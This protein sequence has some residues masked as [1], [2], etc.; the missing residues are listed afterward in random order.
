TSANSTATDLRPELYTGYYHEN[1][2]NAAGYGYVEF[3]STYLTT[4][5]RQLTGTDDSIIVYDSGHSGGSFDT[6]ITVS[7]GGSY[8]LVP[9]K[10]H[11]YPG[12]GL[13]YIFREWRAPYGTLPLRDYTLRSGGMFSG[14]TIFY[15][16]DI[17]SNAGP[18][19]S[20]TRT[21]QY[22]I[23]GNPLFEDRVDSTRGRALITSFPGHQISFGYNSLIIEALGRTTKI[24]FDTIARSGSA[25]PSETM[26]YANYGGITPASLA[27]A[28]YPETEPRLYKSFF[29]YVTQ[30]I[31]PENRVTSFEYEKV[32]RRY[33]DFNFPWANPG[34]GHQHLTLKNYRL[35]AVNEPTARYAL[36]Y[37]SDLSH[38]I[39]VTTEAATDGPKKMNDVA[40]SVYK[41]DND[42]NRLTTSAYGFTYLHTTDGANLP[43]MTSQ[44][45]VDNVTGQSRM[46]TFTYDALAL[47]TFNVL[48][49]QQR[50]TYLK[51]T[52]QDDGTILSTVTENT[53]K[54][55]T[56]LGLTNCISDYVILPTETKTTVNGIIKSHQYFAHTLDTLR[57]YG[58]ERTLAGRFGMGISRKITNTVR[59]DLSSNILLRDTVE[60]LNLKQID[61]AMSWNERRWNKLATI[62]HY[63]SLRAAD[64]PAV[65]GRKWEQV[66]YSPSVAVVDEVTIDD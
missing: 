29:G 16:E 31:D 6:T 52:Q 43:D 38:D 2:G 25:G 59:P 39:V 30:I 27:L 53:Y 41:Y 20:F 54:S 5:L 63:L 46:T 49:P 45:V 51:K 32:T 15:L 62:D 26:P 4:Q 28:G 13:E 55:G 61:S 64:D 57:F 44:T 66:M 48:T 3:D 19:A 58:G 34:S 12:D 35:K 56:A 36:K 9:R 60:Y 24:K 1:E 21:R 37:Y 65:H 11:Y 17:R 7:S 42:G 10:L 50:Y 14:P 33:E 22:P 40:D 47:S 8:A 18:V 23:F